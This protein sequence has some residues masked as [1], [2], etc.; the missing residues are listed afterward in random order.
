MQNFALKI[1]F[2]LLLL[3]LRL[4]TADPQQSAP[5]TSPPIKVSK[6]SFLIHPVCW[7][8]ALAK[9]NRIGPNFRYQSF[10]YRGGSLV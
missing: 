3:T 9:G 5:V 8:L 4:T 1:V 2:I 7:D 6:V 10:T